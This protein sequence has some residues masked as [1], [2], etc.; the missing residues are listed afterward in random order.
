MPPAE[1]SLPYTA[2]TKKRC[3]MLV[4]RIAKLYDIDTTKKEPSINSFRGF[5]TDDEYSY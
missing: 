3:D 5:Y 1:L 4:E 2:N